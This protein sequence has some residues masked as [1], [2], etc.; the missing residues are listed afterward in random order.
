MIGKFITGL[1]TLFMFGS[2]FAPALAITGSE[3]ANQS[4]PPPPQYQQQN[5]WKPFNEQQ[6]QEKIEKEFIVVRDGITYK[7]KVIEVIENGIV[8]KIIENQKPEGNKE[9]RELKNIDNIK[10]EDEVNDE[11]FDDGSVVD[12]GKRCAEFQDIY[13]EDKLCKY[14]HKAKVKSVVSPNARFFANAP[15]SRAQFAAMVVRAFG[16]T[17]DTTNTEPFADVDSTDKFY[18]P[19]MVLKELG[20]VTGAQ[21]EDGVTRYFPR[22]PISRGEAIKI[23]VNTLDESGKFKFEESV[24]STLE[25]KFKDEGLDQDKFAEYIKKLYSSEGKMPELIV[26]GYSDGFLR[27]GRLVSRMEAIVMITRAMWAAGLVD[28]VEEIPVDTGTGSSID[29][30][31]DMDDDS[32]DE[33][34]DDMDDDNDDD[35]DDDQSEV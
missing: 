35:S 12:E 16:F 15:V 28:N 3:N 29:D 6:R 19:I 5:M 21:L 8:K 33:E 18:P 9:Y 27:T 26:K 23:L 10:P 34:D 25:N 22:K 1:V 30:D 13:A 24:L 7:V 14:L 20:I 17:A 4:P 2:V 32:E 31:D 11:D